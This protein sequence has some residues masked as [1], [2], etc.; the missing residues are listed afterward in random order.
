MKHVMVDIETLDNTS[1]SVILSIGACTFDDTTF[2]SSV[3]YTTVDPQSCVNLGMT[4]SVDTVMWW[5]KQSEQAR[6][7]LT[8]GAVMPLSQALLELSA[9]WPAGAAFW[10]NGATFDNVI[11]A[12]AYRR[13]QLSRPWKY[14]AD[15]CYRTLKALFPEITADERTGTYHNALD[16]ALYQAAHASKILAYMKGLQNGN[17]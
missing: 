14:S 6:A 4:L 16:D 17:V 7:A 10:G 1:T 5:M 9:W 2:G 11:V 13:T 15:R 8:T 12:D 3:F